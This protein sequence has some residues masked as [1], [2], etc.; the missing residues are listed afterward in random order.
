MDA[1]RAKK[2]PNKVDIVLM[3]TNFLNH[4]AMVYYRAEAKSRGLPIVYSTRHVDCVKNEFIKVISNLDNNTEICKTCKEYQK[5][6][7]EQVVIEDFFFIPKY[8]IDESIKP[9]AVG[10]ELFALEYC[11]EV[12]D[13]PLEYVD[14][15]IYTEEGLEITLKNID[16]N[17]K[18][19]DEDWYIQIRRLASYA[20]AS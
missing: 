4:N 11:E 9:I 15:S 1:N 18:I 20:R 5:C 10:Y 17:K 8:N 6:H 7:E 3:L 13:I 2:I 16:N 12:L 19:F 14:E